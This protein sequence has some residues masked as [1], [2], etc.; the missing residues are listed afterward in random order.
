MYTAVF[1]RSTK[2]STY[3]LLY[4]ICKKYL[5]IAF[6]VPGGGFT[7]G[8]NLCDVEPKKCICDTFCTFAV[9]IDSSIAFRISSSSAADRG[10]CCCWK[11]E[12]KCFN[13]LAE[14]PEADA[15]LSASS[16]SKIINFGKVL[17]SSIVH[18]L[19]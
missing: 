9:T 19:K 12:T 16:Y 10:S 18:T 1:P 14:L 15:T 6:T 8:L 5:I 11:F 2:F 3:F 13:W 7:S 4:L 17:T